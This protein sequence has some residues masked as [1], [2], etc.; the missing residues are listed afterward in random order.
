VSSISVATIGSNFTTLPYLPIPVVGEGK[1]LPSSST[2]RARDEL[3]NIDDYLMVQAKK[4]QVDNPMEKHNYVDAW[5][6]ANM[7]I[8]LGPEQVSEN[9]E[10]THYSYFRNRMKTGSNCWVQLRNQHDDP[11]HT[12]ATSWV[13]TAMTV[14]SIQP[15]EEM[16][17]YLLEQQNSEGWWPLYEN[18]GKKSENANT[19][20]TAVALWSLEEGLKRKLIQKNLIE[21]AQSKVENARSW[22][23]TAKIGP[24]E[25]SIYPNRKAT[26]K[27]SVTI[28]TIV[29]YVLLITKSDSLNDSEAEKCNDAF[30][31]EPLKITDD[32]YSSGEII[33][34]DDGKLIEDGVNH[35]KLVWKILALSKLYPHLSLTGK[36]QIRKYVEKSL[37]TD[38]TSPE[39]SLKLPWQ[40]AELA[41][42]LRS[43][44]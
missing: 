38:F 22:L 26:T 12:A 40:K 29:I 37:F 11:C 34:T 16:W 36:S 10:K 27:P 42:M 25:W 20:S 14:N 9:L 18:S 1:P 41:L 28:S 43:I 31:N 5:T 39:S 8:G 3:K 13:L 15:S 44:L 19:Y 21:K 23:K 32:M 30:I 17:S 6:Y 24:C 2:K 35:Q 4:S 33:A 7:M